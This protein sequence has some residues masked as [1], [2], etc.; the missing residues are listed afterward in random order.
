[1]IV[2]SISELLPAPCR[3]VI[4]NVSTKEVSTLALL[5]TL[6]YSQLPVLLV[7]LESSDGSLA[8]FARM[9]ETEPR[10]DLCSASLRKHGVVLDRI[11]RECRDASLLLVDSDLEIHDA[12]IVKRMLDAV[13]V[14]GVFG[15]GA[16]HGPSWLGKAH[17][18][19]ERVA[20]YR[21]RMW[22]P[23]TVLKVASIQDALKNGYSFI[24]RWVPNEVPGLPWLAKQLSR[25]FFV[26]V[27]KH[28]RADFLGGTRNSYG[29]FRPN[30]V[31]CDTGADIFCY[32]RDNCKEQFVDFGI[33][34][35]ETLVHHYHG[36]TRRRLNRRDRNATDLDEILA[37]VVDRL[38][39]E[40]GVVFPGS[41]SGSTSAQNVRVPE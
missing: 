34:Q 25:R 13:A 7:D 3:A 11:F 19:P 18:L 27:V 12:G 2:R 31:C 8:H 9:A 38:H 26:P 40:Y 21:E 41:A 32:L 1:M 24:N 33:G 6:R 4:V 29:D 5:S 37:Q 36:I 10:I 20:L 39:Q 16:I 35:V 14:P 23:F 15:A 30:L 17:G 22:I 28:I